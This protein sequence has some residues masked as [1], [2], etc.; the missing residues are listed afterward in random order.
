M[1]HSP[2]LEALTETRKELAGT[3]ESH[4]VAASQALADIEQHR[5]LFGAER[6]PDDKALRQAYR[7]RWRGSSW[8]PS[9]RPSAACPARNWRKG[10]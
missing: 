8:A 1:K 6:D 3:L 5:L 10:C 7:G 9:P 2:I 4:Q